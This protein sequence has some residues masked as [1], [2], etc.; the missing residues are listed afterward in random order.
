MLIALI[1]QIRNPPKRDFIFLS[2]YCFLTTRVMEKS[3]YYKQ[4]KKKKKQ[5]GEKKPVQELQN[6]SFLFVHLCTLP[7]HCMN[8][9]ISGKAAD[10]ASWCEEEHPGTSTPAFLLQAGLLYIIQD[11]EE[12][13][14]PLSEIVYRRTFW[15]F[16][17]THFHSIPV[18]ILLHGSSSYWNQ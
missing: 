16:F 10:I 15:Y 12:V 5:W 6:W 4:I 9:G 3:Y 17:I 18:M 14:Y 11:R 1:E 13:V 8:K 7:K 2:C